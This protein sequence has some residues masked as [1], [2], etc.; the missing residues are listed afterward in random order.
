MSDL[1]ENDFVILYPGVYNEK[2]HALIERYLV[3]DKA[4]EERCNVGVQTLVVVTGRRCNSQV[5]IQ[6]VTR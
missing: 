4:F 5:A 6:K 2:E 3:D 1:D